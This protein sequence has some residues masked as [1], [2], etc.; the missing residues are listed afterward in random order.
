MIERIRLINLY[1][2]GIAG[3]TIGDRCFLGDGVTLDT[4]EAEYKEKKIGSIGEITVF[5][6]YVTKNIA[7]GECGKVPTNDKKLAEFIRNSGARTVSLL[8]GANLSQKDIQDVV[9]SVAW[10][11]ETNR[12]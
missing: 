3:I 1:R 4:A 8:L 5:S 7:T 10:L 11:I 2:T 12:K 6:F 9:D